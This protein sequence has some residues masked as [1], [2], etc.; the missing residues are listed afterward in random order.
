MIAAEVP[1]VQDIRTIGRE[2]PIPIS[3]RT[4]AAILAGRQDIVVRRRPY[5]VPGDYLVLGS[6]GQQRTWV[7]VSVAKFPLDLVAQIM[8][9]SAGAEDPETFTASWMDE[10]GGRWTPHRAVHVHCFEEVL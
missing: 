8:Y 1:Q 5:G 10:H 7:L 4:R 6:I 9:R 2:M 3:D